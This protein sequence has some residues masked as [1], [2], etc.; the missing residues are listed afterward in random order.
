MSRLLQALALVCV[1]LIVLLG[2]ETFYLVS[3]PNNSAKP[4]EIRVACVGDSITA[5]TEYPVDLWNLLGANYTVGNFGIGGAT[6]AVCTN[7]S[8]VNMTAFE[9]AKDYQPDIVVIILGTNDADTDY[10]ETNQQFVAD[11]VKLIGE[12]QALPSKPQ[13]YITLPTPIFPNNGTISPEY[14]EANVLP[15]IREV[16]TQTGLPLID[17][18]TPLLAHPEFFEDGIHP[19]YEGARLIAS[20]V[21]SAISSNKG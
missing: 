14:F 17:L 21:Y 18:Y 1:V 4:S 15:S 12:F 6:V 11:Y 16:A 19:D 7:A 8:W 9:V 13:V 20:T 3:M 10:N 5:G 2:V